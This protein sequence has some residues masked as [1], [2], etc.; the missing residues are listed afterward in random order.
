MLP[1]KETFKDLCIVLGCSYDIL[2]YNSDQVA[3]FVSMHL[4][5]YMCS[6]S[7]EILSVQPCLRPES[8]P[9]DC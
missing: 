7:R 2:S 4:A 3:T 6:W 8:S 9:S 5:R 1:L